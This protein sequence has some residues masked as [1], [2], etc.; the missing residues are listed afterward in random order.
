[1]SV[2]EWCFLVVMSVMLLIITFLT[3]NI[4]LTVGT[5]L[6]VMYLRK[7]SSSIPIPK[8][9]R[10]YDIVSARTNKVLKAESKNN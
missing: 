4:Y 5:F 2:F 6:L 8:R 9:F 3:K 10:K 1:M 7:H